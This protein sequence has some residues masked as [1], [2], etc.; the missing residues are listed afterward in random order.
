MPNFVS[1]SIGAAV[2]LI[3]ALSLATSASTT[4]T[5]ARV[6]YRS[7]GPTRLAA[8]L[9]RYDAMKPGSERDKLAAEIDTFAGQRYATVSRLFWHTN[10]DEAKAAAH[11]QKQPILHLRLLGRLD[12]ELSCANS[13]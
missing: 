10:L 11:A 6:A 13:R 12:E 9:A 2:G 8:M 5:L 7:E 3:A 1:L 4:V